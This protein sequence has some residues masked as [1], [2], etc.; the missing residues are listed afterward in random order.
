MRTRG[1]LYVMGVGAGEVV[2]IYRKVRATGVLSNGLFWFST[3]G[4]AV[5]LPTVAWLEIASW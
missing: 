5:L 1:W 2:R 3:A 4:V